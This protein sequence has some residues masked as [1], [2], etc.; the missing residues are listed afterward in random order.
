MG[1]CW[2]TPSTTSAST[3][4]L[5]GERLTYHS[6]FYV[7]HIYAKEW[8]HSQDAKLG[9]PALINKL[10]P[11]W[12]IFKTKTNIWL[13]KNRICMAVFFFLSVAKSINLA[14]LCVIISYLWV[15]FTATTT[16]GLLV[17][18]LLDPAWVSWFFCGS[19]H[20]SEVDKLCA[21]NTYNMAEKCFSSLLFKFRFMSCYKDKDT[22]AIGYILGAAEPVNQLGSKISQFKHELSDWTVW[23][24]RKLH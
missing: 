15:C 2:F 20:V 16:R 23:G 24:E 10:D 4:R 9:S 19:K 1:D 21:I 7:H 3:Y 18:P 5:Q 8:V 14:F 6:H 22:S 11:E 13:L 12:Y 17:H